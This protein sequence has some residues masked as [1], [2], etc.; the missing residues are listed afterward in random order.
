M[1]VAGF[2]LA[3]LLTA[4]AQSASDIAGRWRTQDGATVEI[5]DCGG[6]PCGKIIS[7]P[8]PPG[9]TQQTA[10]DIRN[11]DASK[12]GRKILGLTILWR[13]APEGTGWKGRVYDPRRG[14]SANAT[15]TRP[16]ANQLSIRGCVR[17]IFNVCE[18]ETWRRT[19]D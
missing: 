12:R 18:T 3:L 1:L 16:D 13:L 17:A 7:F 5:S 4:P 10:M 2:L 9:E 14:F 11:R 8:P 19:G 6:A 15:V